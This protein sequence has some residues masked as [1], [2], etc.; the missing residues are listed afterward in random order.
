[1][2]NLGQALPAEEMEIDEP[3]PDLA[4]HL[5]RNR[6]VYLGLPLTP[7]VTELMYSQLIY[8]QYEDSESPIYL[9]INSTGVVKVCLRSISVSCP[10]PV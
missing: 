6:I 8:L 7:E 3:P 10:V 2:K 4:S 1:M 9:Y 5:L